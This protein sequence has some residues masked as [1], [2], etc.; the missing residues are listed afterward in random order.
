MAEREWPESGDFDRRRM[1]NWTLIR[2]LRTSFL[3]ASGGMKPRRHLTQV[4]REERDQR[5]TRLNQ[6]NRQEAAALM[7]CAS[8]FWKVTSVNEV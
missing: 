5:P 6:Q 4:S 7:S 3:G 8:A 2:R 1:G